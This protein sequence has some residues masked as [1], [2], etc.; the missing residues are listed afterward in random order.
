MYADVPQN[1]LG[2]L[3]S[4]EGGSGGVVVPPLTFW[5]IKARRLGVQTL[6]KTITKPCVDTGDFLSLLL[7]PWRLWD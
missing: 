1:P 3:L 2:C 7:T 5:C 6:L 4:N